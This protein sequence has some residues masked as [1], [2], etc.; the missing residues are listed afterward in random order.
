MSR[1]LSTNFVLSTHLRKNKININNLLCNSRYFSSNI[2]WDDSWSVKDLLLK[3]KDDNINNDDPSVISKDRLKKLSNL[4]MLSI[5]ED[6]V[7]QYCDDLSGFLNSVE[8]IQSVNTDNVK[9]LHSILED[10][11][12]I[13]HHEQTTVNQDHE[14]VLNHSNNVQG[15]FFTVPKQ[16]SSHTNSQKNNNNNTIVDDEEF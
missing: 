12:L 11:Q 6:K 16:I 2:K 14:Y 5:P 13:L 1:Y 4:A 9:P 8:S 7:Q 15:G 10:V 3:S